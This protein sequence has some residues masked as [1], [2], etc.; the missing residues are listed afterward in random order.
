MSQT[1]IITKSKNNLKTAYCEVNRSLVLNILS[2]EWFILLC[3][4]YCV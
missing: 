4:T 3:F 1:K 2:P